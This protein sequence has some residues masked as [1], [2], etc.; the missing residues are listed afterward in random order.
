MARYYI[1]TALQQMLR[2]RAQSIIVVIGVAIGVANIILLMSMTDMG[3]RQTLGQL[4]KFGARLLI[5]MPHVDFSAGPFAMFSQANASGHLPGAAYDA[6]KQSP[7][8]SH[9]QSEDQ[10]DVSAMLTLNGHGRWPG[11]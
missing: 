7:H 8:L 10:A 9:E 3:R 2:Y 5:I 11:H 1:A 6:L 4:E